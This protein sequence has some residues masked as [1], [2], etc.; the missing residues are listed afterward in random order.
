MFSGRF[1]TKLGDDGAYFIDRDGTHFR[2]ILNYLRTGRLLL[3]DDELIREELLEEAEFYQIEGLIYE[4]IPPPCEKSTLQLLSLP[5][6][7]SLKEWLKGTT[8][9]K[10]K[11]S[12][13]YRGSRDGWSALNFHTCC[14]R[15]GPTL[16]VA[17][18][19]YNYLFGGYTE[20]QWDCKYQERREL[21]KSPRTGKWGSQ[22][23]HTRR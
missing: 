21:I 10:F 15:R 4:L 19:N 1:E 11:A 23:P 22:Y 16:V 6:R 7:Q 17:R 12:L 20:Q 18:S 14:D 8:S 13:I 9:G 5:Q 3:P 2:Y